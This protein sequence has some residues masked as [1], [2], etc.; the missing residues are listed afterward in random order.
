MFTGLINST[1][2]I[3][4]LS[5]KGQGIH[6][7]IEKPKN[8]L[9]W[10]KG[11]SI[12]I[13]GICLSLEKENTSYL[14]FFAQNETIKN[15]TC[16]RLKVKEKVNLERA[17]KLGSRIGGH[18]VQGHVDGLGKVIKKIKKGNSFQYKFNCPKTLMPYIILKGSVAIDG[19]SLTVSSV[20]SNTF[21]VDII[22]L[23][24]SNTNIASSWKISHYVNIET[25][26]MNRQIHHSVE[27]ILKNKKF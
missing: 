13:N 7:C 15:T 9:D 3:L 2:K 25:D 11:E 18:I 27:L 16:K 19:I 12:S 10:K 21:T 24:L 1:V 22:P 6:I 17:V 20:Q 8:D 23:T 14:S 26:I 4:S 5:L